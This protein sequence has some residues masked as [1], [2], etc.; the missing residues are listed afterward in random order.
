MSLLPIFCSPSK[1]RREVG[2]LFYLILVF[3]VFYF[4]WKDF[5]LYV[6]IQECNKDGQNFTG[7][8][9]KEDVSI[10]YLMLP[11]NMHYLELPLAEFMEHTFKLSNDCIQAGPYTFGPRVPQ[12]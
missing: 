5:E 12:F 4:M 10:K 1:K 9:A 6:F 7:C 2:P 3:L 8:F 11:P